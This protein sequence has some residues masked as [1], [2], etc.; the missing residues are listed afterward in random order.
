MTSDGGRNL[1]FMGLLTVG[2]VLVACIILGYLLGSWLDR[3]LGTG[4]WLLVTGVFLG[5]AAGFVGLFRTVSRS[6]K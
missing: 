5:T 3:R 2:M 6:L 4:P 1:K